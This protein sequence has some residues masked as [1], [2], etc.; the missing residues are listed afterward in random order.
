MSGEKKEQ[1]GI[2]SCGGAETHLHGF[3]PYA[4]VRQSDTTVATAAAG[5]SL[6]GGA[7]RHLGRRTAAVLAGT[8]ER[9]TWLREGTKSSPSYLSKK[10]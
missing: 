9:Q 1:E 6:A 3:S 2:K 7:C 8:N 5:A 4:V 10:Y